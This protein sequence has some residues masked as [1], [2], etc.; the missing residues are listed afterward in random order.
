MVGG[1]G[2]G[3]A[4]FLR[5]Y[6]AS[7]GGRARV[8]HV[9]EEPA[10]EAHYA[11]PSEP[12]SPAIRAVLAARGAERL[13]THQAR[14]LDLAAARRDFLVA[15]GPA[16]G[17][18]LC[19]LLPLLAR[20]AENP[21]ATALLLYPTKALARDQFL[22]VE[23][24]L[25][26]GGFTGVTAGV[27]DGDTPSNL[28]RRLRDRARILLT[29]PDTLHAAILPAHGRF[30]SFLARLSTVVV[31]EIHVYRGIF[32]ANA[33]W[34]FRRLF[35]V[36]RHHGAAPLV[37]AATATLANPAEHAARL[38]GRPLELLAGDGSP[39]GHRTFLLVNPPR[40]R[41]TKVR[42]RRSA[43][44]EAAEVFAAL[45][46]RGVRAIAFSKAK[47]TAEM[48][49]RYA[50]EE[51]PA[52]AARISPYR[53][54]LLPEERRAV[55]EGL[56]AGRLLG[57]SAT[58]ALELGIDVGGLDAAVIAGWPGRLSSF[59]QQ[60]GRAGRRGDDSLVVFVALDTPAN[61]WV[62][63]HPGEIFERPVE[64]VVFDRGNPFV[65]LAGLRCA[66]FELPVA[67]EEARGI[68]PDAES[69]LEVL[70]ENRKLHA[71]G[72]RFHHCAPEV[73]AHE[74]SLRDRTDRNVVVVEEGSQRVIGE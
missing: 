51:A 31:D 35:R 60:A 6:L 65:L 3:V 68:H 13:Y 73:P 70:A 22:A 7:P 38:L 30:A 17:K 25:G 72:G 14:A 32:G 11:E 56:I 42:S 50:A 16:S 26:D 46:R 61:Q 64:E 48:I 45:L 20:L 57:V 41:D 36:A 43:N 55:E 21:D 1:T 59:L 49:A 10:R 40:V 8:V 44:I 9:R 63:R 19:F 34:L 66:A 27:F 69:A 4:A 15:T 62:L 74:I 28:R 12:L 5:D 18:T 58:P 2:T 67:P 24:A 39:R 71:A 23:R 33:S 37:I 52:L 54:G 29:N 47:I 53:A